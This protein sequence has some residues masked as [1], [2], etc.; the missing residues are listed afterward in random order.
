[1]F[2]CCYFLE[3]LKSGVGGDLLEGRIYNPVVY[4]GDSGVLSQTEPPLPVLITAFSHPSTKSPLLPVPQE[5]GR[6]VKVSIGG[7]YSNC[8]FRI[9]LLFPT[10]I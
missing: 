3:L 4:P 2:D 1:M 8:L 5:N 6:E 9:F 10:Q 7:S